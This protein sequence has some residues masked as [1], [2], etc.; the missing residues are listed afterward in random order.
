M[1]LTNSSIFRQCKRKVFMKKVIY[2]FG[3]LYFGLWRFPQQLLHDASVVN[4]EVSVRV[5]SDGLFVDNLSIDDFEVYEDG[6]PQ[7]VEDI[8]LIK[9]SAIRRREEVAAYATRSAG[10]SVTARRVSAGST[11]SSRSASP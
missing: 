5:F 8:Y 9:K 10:S 7:K 6:K 11:P 2:F 1:D 3:L 4:V